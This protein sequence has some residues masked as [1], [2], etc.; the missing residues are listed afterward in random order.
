MFKIMRKCLV[1]R[2]NDS[3]DIGGNFKVFGYASSFDADSAKNAIFGIDHARV[4]VFGTSEPCVNNNTH[5]VLGTDFSVQDTTVVKFPCGDG[6]KVFLDLKNTNEV[7]GDEYSTKYFK[8]FHLEKVHKAT[9]FNL[10]TI[11]SKFLDIDNVFDG[12][13]DLDYLLNPSIVTK[14]SI[15]A[16]RVGSVT[17]KMNVNNFTALEYFFLSSRINAKDVSIDLDHLPESL[18]HIEFITSS[19]KAIGSI[20]SIT[21]TNMERIQV[22]GATNVTGSLEKVVEGMWAKGRRSGACVIIIQRTSATF[23]GNVPN[24]DTTAKFDNSGVTIYKKDAPSGDI[25][26]TYNGTTWS[27]N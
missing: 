7:I 5:E 9:K 15:S 8:N 22:I 3:V 18:T 21:K 2:L 26:A 17:A 23:N 4:K 11:E 12:V 24:F 19:I 14:V 20:N 1:T 13:L 10:G 16:N 25:V 27:Y 6:V